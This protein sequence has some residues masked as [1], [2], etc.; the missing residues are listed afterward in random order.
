MTIYPFCERMQ[1]LY[2]RITRV[3]GYESTWYSSGYDREEDKNFCEYNFKQSGTYPFLEAL[4]KHRAEMDNE[5]D[6]IAEML[7]K[8]YQ[9]QWTV[10][11][12]SE[13]SRIMHNNYYLTPDQK[14]TLKEYYSPF[15]HTYTTFLNIT[16]KFNKHDSAKILGNNWKLK[17]IFSNCK[18]TKS[19]TVEPYYRLEP[20]VVDEIINN[21]FLYVKCGW[22]PNEN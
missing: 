1:Q 19:N 10:C 21:Y 15:V 11:I 14:N 4:T 2:Y 13:S 9:F 22:N 7:Q 20:T 12:K 5:A 17:K 18:S 8:K 3:M 16:N 6:T